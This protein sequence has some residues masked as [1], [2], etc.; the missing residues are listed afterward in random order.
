VIDVAGGADDVGHTK[1]GSTFGTDNII[2]LKNAYH[3]T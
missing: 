1:F 3:C 2:W